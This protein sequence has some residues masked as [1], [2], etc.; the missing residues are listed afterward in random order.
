MQVDPGQDELARRRIVSADS[1][2]SVHIAA[3]TMVTVIRLVHVPEKNQVEGFHDRG[4]TN[5]G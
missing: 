2:G 4:E 3:R 5:A 1:C